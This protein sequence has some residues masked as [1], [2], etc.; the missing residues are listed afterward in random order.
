MTTNSSTDPTPAT[1]RGAV[2]TPSADGAPDWFAAH[3]AQEPVPGRVVL[4]GC[5]IAWLR[6]GEPTDP[7]L[8]LVHGGGA[9]ARWWAP[10]APFFTGGPARRWC[11]LA[12]DLAGMGDSGWHPEGYRVE[13]WADELVA[14][15]HDAC[16]YPSAP[17]VLVGHSLGATVVGTAAVRHA[18]RL[19]GVVLCDI[20][21]R[22]AGEQRRSGRHFQNRVTYGTEAEAIARFKLI[23]RQPCP[24]P[25]YVRHI[26]RASVRPVGAGGAEDPSRP[27]PGEERG[28]TWK[29][30]WR[31]FARHADQPFADYLRTLGAGGLPVA[32]LNGEL[33]RIVTSE[34][35]GRVAEL[36]GPKPVVWVPDARHHLMV[37]QPVGFVTA[38]RALLDGH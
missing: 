38:L 30:D 13:T 26:A 8:V 16:P 28:W 14:A 21:V 29:F 7:P 11:V 35:A 2:P 25:W 20:G 31:L 12:V 4:D 27:P 23:P 3:L 22:G 15:V 36:L 19:G 18:D 10:L 37:D 33:S 17:P 1:E 6:W 9:H 5:P 24:N 34:V 32:C